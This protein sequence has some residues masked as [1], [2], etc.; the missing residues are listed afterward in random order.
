MKGNFA[1]FGG[2]L[3]VEYTFNHWNRMKWRVSVSLMLST[4]FSTTPVL[5][6]VYH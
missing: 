4:T 6:I 3:R 1:R 2:N 5:M